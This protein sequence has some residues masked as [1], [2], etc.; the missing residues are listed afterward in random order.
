MKESSLSIV[1][2]HRES[3]L[4]KESSLERDDSGESRHSLQLSLERVVSGE[5]PIY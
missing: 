2:S 4:S 1:V 3:R 5:I